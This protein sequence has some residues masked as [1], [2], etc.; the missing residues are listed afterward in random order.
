MAVSVLGA[1]QLKPLFR[2]L[3]WAEKPADYRLAGSA[4]HRGRRRILAV[5]LLQLD[6]QGV[7]I[8]GRIRV[9]AGRQH[10]GI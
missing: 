5:A 1:G 10:A 6:K 9:A 4:R 8:V 7:A 3:D 2:K